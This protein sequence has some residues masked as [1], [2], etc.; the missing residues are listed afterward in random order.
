MR[1][2]RGGGPIPVQFWGGSPIL[3]RGGPILG[4]GTGSNSAGEGGRGGPILGGRGSNSAGGEGEGRGVQFCWEGGQ[5]LGS[6]LVS[7]L[8]AF[9]AHSGSIHLRNILI[10]V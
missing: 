9:W 8:G 4:R 6:I 5:I 1:W 3:G 2:G 7:I 10:I